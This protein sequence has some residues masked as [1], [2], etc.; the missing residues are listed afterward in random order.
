MFRCSCPAKFLAVVTLALLAVTACNRV[1]NVPVPSEAEPNAETVADR[2]Q[3]PAGELSI[4]DKTPPLEI[5]HW[6]KGKQVD[7]F[8]DGHVYVVEFWATW[9]GPCLAGMPHMSQLQERF[10]GR[11]TFIGV[12]D[13]EEETVR[14]FLGRVQNPETA[15]TWDQVVKYTIAIDSDG[16]TNAAYMKAAGQNGIPMAFVVGKDGYVEWVGH[17]M[18]IDAPLESIVAGTWDRVAARAKFTEEQAVQSVM[19][20]VSRALQIAQ[21]NGDWATALELLDDAIEQFPT[22][23]QLKMSKFAVLLQAEEFASANAL[24]EEMANENWDNARPLEQI[25]WVMATEVSKPHRNLELALRIAT[26]ASSL[27]DNEDAS[28]LDTV[29][30][31]CY[32]QGDLK[33]AVAWQRK[34]VQHDTNGSGSI[35]ET[36]QKYEAELGRDDEMTTADDTSETDR[37]TS[38]PDSNASEAKSVDKSS[39]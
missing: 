10:S 8:Q 12:S 15:E 39:E 33:E 20:N 19:M 26:R 37:D 16:A 29:A 24:A 31:V 35:K 6:I 36:L 27:E 32:E 4:G 5:A 22:L 14:S 38:K 18:A 23:D 13:E 1:Q 28:M 3:A 30:R 34:A 11:V 7:G 2:E 9:C 21:Q 17:P 25:A